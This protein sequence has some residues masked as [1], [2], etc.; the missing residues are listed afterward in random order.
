MHTG[1]R[2][3]IKM[4][5]VLLLWYSTV[6]ISFK[7]YVI[8]GIITNNSMSEYVPYKRFLLSE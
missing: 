7:L 8:Y 3:K 6:S 5:A 2:G 1:L 4:S